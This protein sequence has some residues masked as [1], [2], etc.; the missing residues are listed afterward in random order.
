M[1]FPKELCKKITTS[2]P[3][4]R[5]ARS[6]DKCGMHWLSWERMATSKFRGGLGFL[7]LEIINDAMLAKQACRLLDNL[8]S[9]RAGVL[10]GRYYT[11][12]GFIHAGCPYSVSP[13]W[14][15]II[16]RREALKE[17]LIPRIGDGR[18]IEIRHD[19]W[20]SGTT[21][22]KPVCTISDI[23]VQLVADLIKGRHWTME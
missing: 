2:M 5:W 8:N 7:N 16:K 1:T 3:K 14:R 13:T 18:T 21:S 15:A 17:G 11:D 12:G 20:I 9:L 22:I 4:Y 23:P 19:R 6:L 10:C